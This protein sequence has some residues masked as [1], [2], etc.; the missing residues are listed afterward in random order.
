MRRTI[1]LLAAIA[2]AGCRDRGDGTRTHVAAVGSSTVFPFTAAVA[3]RFAA[4]RTG[5]PAPVIES[6]GTGGGIRIFCGGVGDA[7]PDLVDASR[8]MTAAEYRGC[9][10][11]GAG[12]LMEVPIGLDGIVLVQ[13]AAADPLAL[14]ATAVYRA[15]AA[16]P[17]G[18]PNRARTWHD[19]DRSLPARRIL[20]YG[21]PATSGTRDALATLVV[22]A[23]CAQA[24]AGHAP[25][26]RAAS[27]TRLRE[28]GA[29]VDAGEDDQLVIQKL[30]AD[31]DAIGVLGYG[32]VR[33]A[34]AA[35][36]PIPLD[37]MLPDPQTIASGRYPGARTL[38][39]YVKRARLGRV[40]WLRAFLSLYAASWGSGGL[41][42][43]KGLVP[44]PA[45]ARARA[46]AVVARETPLDPRVLR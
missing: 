16:E 38:Y 25:D 32:V 12:D 45:A 21:P 41:L 5:S 35:V 33:D 10:A 3:E 6:T 40:P 22:A 11:R 46:E 19:V 44:L 23:G 8:R 13:S 30:A 29:Y 14:T 9:A 36:R 42:A 7:F 4:G 39:L 26:R 27:C 20:V 43:R 34:G 1:L 2:S 15:L 17:D 28:D 24:T 31:P 18:R 37:T